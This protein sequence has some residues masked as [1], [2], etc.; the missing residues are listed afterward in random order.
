[1][2]GAHVGKMRAA[3]WVRCVGYTTVG[4]NTGNPLYYS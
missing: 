2:Q 4:D 1:M 3:M